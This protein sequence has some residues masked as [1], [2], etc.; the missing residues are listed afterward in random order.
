MQ[1]AN[2]LFSTTLITWLWS[3]QLV[4]RGVGLVFA[5][6]LVQQIPMLNFSSNEEANDDDPYRHDYIECVHLDLLT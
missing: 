5:K 3:W 1:K 4:L 2:G 6:Q